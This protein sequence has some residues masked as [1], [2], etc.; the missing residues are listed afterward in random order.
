L[1][2]SNRNAVPTIRVGADATPPLDLARRA[3]W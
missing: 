1:C 2:C 3:A